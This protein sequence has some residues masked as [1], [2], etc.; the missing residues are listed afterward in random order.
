MATLTTFSA[1]GDTGY[2][3]EVAT[4][5]KSVTAAQND[6]VELVK[7]RKGWVVFD[8]IVKYAGTASSTVTVGDADD[9]DRFVTSTSTASDGMTRMNNAAGLGYEYTVDDTIDLTIGGAGVTAK[10]YTVQVIFARTFE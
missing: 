4:V 10:N 9:A 2:K 1:Y 5:T 8:V 6:V 3:L 7:V